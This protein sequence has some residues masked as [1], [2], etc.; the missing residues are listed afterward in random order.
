MG[1]GSKNKEQKP[2][3]AEN[4]D[5]WPVFVPVY[6]S[7]SDGTMLQTRKKTPISLRRYLISS[8]GGSFSDVSCACVWPSYGL[9]F[10]FRWAFEYSLEVVNNV[11]ISFIAFGRSVSENFKIEK[12]GLI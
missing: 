10:S 8:Y 9:F 1:T 6:I 5:A 12:T 11:I 3:P 7:V 2:V 4:E